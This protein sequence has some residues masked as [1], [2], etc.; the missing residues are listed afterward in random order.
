MTTFAANR[1]F[2]C[3]RAVC[4]LLKAL[5]LKLC[6][7]KQLQTT[8]PDKGQTCWE[9]W[10]HILSKTCKIHKA[11]TVIQTEKNPY[12]YCNFEDSYMDLIRE[13][14]FCFTVFGV[15]EKIPVQRRHSCLE[16]S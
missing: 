9:T 2:I 7:K 8:E 5:K 16:I 4:A 12:S 1:Y 13:L 11:S 15:N 6:I 3:H 10:H 14:D